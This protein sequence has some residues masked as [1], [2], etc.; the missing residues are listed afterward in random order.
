MKKT[1]ALFA[2]TFTVVLAVCMLCACS[3]PS[4]SASSSSTARSTSAS[5]K[6]ADKDPGST[7]HATVKVEGYEPFV[8]DLYPEYAPKTVEIPHH[9]FHHSEALRPGGLSQ[10]PLRQSSHLVRGQKKAVQIAALHLQNLPVK[11]RIDVIRPA[12]K[13]RQAH[14]LLLQDRQ[15][16]HDRHRLAAAAGGRGDQHAS[17]SPSSPRWGF[18]ISA[19]QT[20]LPA[21]GIW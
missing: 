19:M 5:S 2:L 1:A 15:K 3:G 17:H 9:A 16:P 4:T 10:R 7:L 11:Q 8:I 13:R 6:A 21:Q 14:A 18:C 12:L 20:G